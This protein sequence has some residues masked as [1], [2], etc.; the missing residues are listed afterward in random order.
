MLY[1][2]QNIFTVQ[3]KEIHA[4]ASQGLYENSYIRGSVVDTHISWV[5]L[6]RRFAFKIKKPVKFSFLDFSTLALRKELCEKE[7]KLNRR[8]SDIYLDVLPVRFVDSQWIIGGPDD[9]N[10]VDYCVMM[11][12]MATSR[13]LDNM[14]QKHKVDV[15]SIRR[16]ATDIALFHRE[17]DSVYR[18]PDLTT[19][20]AIFNDIGSVRDLTT[21]GLHIEIDSP[22]IDRAMDWSNSFLKKHF[23][24]I[25]QRAECGLKRDLHGDL[26]SGNIFLYPKPVLFDCIE[27]NDSY[28]QIDVLYDIAFL[29]MDLERFDEW[30]LAAALIDEYRKHF[31]AFQEDE[32]YSIFVYFKSLRANIR[33]KVHAQQWK[34]SHTPSELS[35]HTAHVQKYLQLMDKYIAGMPALPQANKMRSIV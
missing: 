31:A 16:L 33:A 29:C 21:D 11:K 5:I 8:F 19:T 7:L 25:Q 18:A 10:V 1:V 2:C 34:E 35:Y 22:S 32:D 15:A 13:R 14:L 23:N 9:V 30:N 28:R 3:D 12:R 17:A 26:H 24:R 20:T 27:F 4:I 6:T